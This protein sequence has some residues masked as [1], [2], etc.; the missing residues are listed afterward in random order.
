MNKIKLPVIFLSMVLSLILTLP[1]NAQDMMSTPSVTVSPE[2]VLDGRVNVFNVVSPGPGFIAIHRDDGEGGFGPVIGTRRVFDGNNFHVEVE[3]DA[4]SATPLMFAMLHTDDNEIGVYEFGTVEGA[5]APVVD[6]GIIVAP[7]F[8]VEVIVTE[9]QFVSDDNTVTIPSVTTQQDGWVAIHTD[10]DGA[11]GPV[12][13]AAQV[14]AG[15]TS[16]V[17]VELEGD[18]T[19]TLWPMLHLDTGEAG[20]YEFGTVE[21]ADAPVIID[22]EVAVTPFSTVPS[23]RVDNQ[24]VR[25]AD[26]NEIDGP[27]TVFAESVLAE[28]DGFL[29]IH[30]E[31]DGGP[32]PVIGFAPVSAGLNT[33]VEV[34]VDASMVTPRLWPML[35]LDTGEE[36]VYE[37]GTVEGADVPVRVNDSVLTFPI[38]A[39]P[40][41]VLE[42]QAIVEAMMGLGPHIFIKEAIV[43]GPAWVAIHSSQD[44]APGPVIGFARLLEG[45]N[46]NVV[47]EIDEMA[48]GD[49]VFPMLHFDTG[50]QGVYEFGTVEGADAP[51]RVAEQVV[52]APMAIL[53][54][55][56]DMGSDMDSSDDMDSDDMDSDSDG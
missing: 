13:G 53:P 12:I 2:V 31:A 52:V 3:I 23:M 41:L 10:A 5:D 27:A 8:G 25:A 24:L 21:G 30:T 1:L 28:E 55:V 35:H 51:V 16:D 29:V 11:P 49:Q 17:V 39:A 7:E 14:A 54:G 43:D 45:V 9:D 32:G 6:D 18:A 47:V 20:V 15:T 38:N 36:G 48:A 19:D 4:S 37:F 50:E 34:E 56:D 22:G 33:D 26:G 46:S 44:G 40:S 42:D